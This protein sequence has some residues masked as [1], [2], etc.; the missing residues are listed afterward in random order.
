M[1][2]LIANVLRNIANR[3]D[4][5]AAVLVVN[6]DQGKRAADVNALKAEYAHLL[7]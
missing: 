2:K 5:P 6:I 7:G 4:R 3:L 1:T